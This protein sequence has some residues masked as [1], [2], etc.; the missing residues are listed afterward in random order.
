MDEIVSHVLELRQRLQIL[1][2]RTARAM[3]DAPVTHVDP[4]KGLCRVRL[5]GTDAE[6]FLSPW[7]P[8]SQMA[9]AVKGHVPVSV[10]QNVSFFAPGGDL[11]Q[12]K[13][14]PFTWSD[15]NASPGSGADPVWTYGSVR[16]EVKTGGVKV[17]VGGASVELTDD[18]FL[19]TAE[20]VKAVGTGMKH[21]A[22]NVGDTHI[23]GGILPGPANTDVPAN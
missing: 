21:N 7:V 18:Q 14:L 8:Y 2:G 6:P 3:R 23:H 20:L 10:G 15:A 16:V 12:G 13:V 9:G 11:V 1:E 4:A 22:K 17:S 19:M 5:G